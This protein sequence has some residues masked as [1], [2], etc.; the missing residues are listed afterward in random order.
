M[1]I[2]DWKWSGR[3]K[4]LFR[5]ALSFLDWIPGGIVGINTGLGCLE[6]D[7]FR[8]GNSFCAM[9][10]KCLWESKERYPEGS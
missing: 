9:L 1:G 10:L 8:K 6:E 4:T 3:E 2:V 7:G 5:M